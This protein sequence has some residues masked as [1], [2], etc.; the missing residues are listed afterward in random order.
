MFFVAAAQA[1]QL[2]VGALGGVWTTA[3][4]GGTLRPESKRYIVGPELELRLPLG[5]SAEFDALYRRFGYT[6]YSSSVVGNSIT[7]VRDNSWEFP[8]IAKFRLPFALGHPFV[9]AGY[10]PRTVS[11]TAVSSGSYLSGLTQNPPASVYTNYSNQRSSAS[12]P[13][14]HGVVVVGGMEVRAG[15]ILVSP[16]IR[17]VRWNAPFLNAEGGDGSFQFSS[18]QNEVFLTLGV[19]WR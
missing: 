2:G 9:G 4:F 8:L 10:A 7:R 3:D 13:L 16:Q 5:F 12:Y 15:P 11:G 14:T 6:G 19:T 17:Y 18:S 1:Q